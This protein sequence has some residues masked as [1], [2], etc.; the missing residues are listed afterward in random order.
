M[1][2]SFIIILKNRSLRQ[3]PCG[4]PALWG[5]VVDM[6]PWKETQAL[7]LVRNADSQR[8]RRPRTP[9]LVMVS[10]IAKGFTSSKDFSRARNTTTPEREH[11]VSKG[12]RRWWCSC[13][14]VRRTRQ[15][16][17]DHAFHDLSGGGEGKYGALTSDALV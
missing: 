11:S 1:G 8:R 4:I 3:L 10:R 2:S 14:A 17:Q 7:W 5:C 13:V 15:T 16:S 6:C 9:F 12:V